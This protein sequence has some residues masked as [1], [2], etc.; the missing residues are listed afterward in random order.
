MQKII[1]FIMIFAGCSGMGLWYSKQF[2]E[3]VKTLRAMCRILEML[4]GQIRFGRSTLG[5]C[6]FQLAERVEEPYRSSF[7]AV[8]EAACSNQGESFGMLCQARLEADLEKLVVDKADKELFISC[9]SQRGY[10]EGRIQIRMIEQTKE[11]LEERLHMLSQ[12]NNSKCK[13]ALSLGMMSGL[14]LIILLV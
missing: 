2:R 12:E 14:L 6:C 4:I 3:Q 5:E 7:F 10:E 1:G 8:Y 13:L 11:E 9:F